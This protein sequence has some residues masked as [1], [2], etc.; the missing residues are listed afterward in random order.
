M[1]SKVE[2]VGMERLR[3]GLP[4]ARLRL[5]LSWARPLMYSSQFPGTL[6]MKPE[7]FLV[8]SGCG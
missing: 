7:R 6:R 5:L 2:R 1:L 8:K 3:P 4:C